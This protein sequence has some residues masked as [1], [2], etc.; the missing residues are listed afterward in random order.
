MFIRTFDWRCL[1]ESCLKILGTIYN[2]IIKENCETKFLVR[3]TQIFSIIMWSKK[4]EDRDAHEAHSAWRNC[5][6]WQERQ[7]QNKK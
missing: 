5:D 4:Q 7:I 3:W 6:T 2:K 1:D